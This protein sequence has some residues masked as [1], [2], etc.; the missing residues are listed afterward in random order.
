ME[1]TL[2]FSRYDEPEPPAPEP[3]PKSMFG[4]IQIVGTDN[5]ELISANAISLPVRV[6][7]EGDT[8]IYRMDLAIKLDGFKPEE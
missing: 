4:R 7:L 6:R 8:R 2:E 5:A 1:P 3:E